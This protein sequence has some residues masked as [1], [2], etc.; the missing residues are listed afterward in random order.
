MYCAVWPYDR[1]RHVKTRSREVRDWRP[2]FRRN[3]WCHR[4]AKCWS[5]SAIFAFP[6]DDDLAS[7]G[8]DDDL[9]SPSKSSDSHADDIID[10]VNQR[11]KQL[12]RSMKRTKQDDISYAKAYTTKLVSAFAAAL[13]KPP[14]NSVR[15]VV[16]RSSLPSTWRMKSSQDRERV[17]SPLTVSGI[18]QQGH[19]IWG[20]P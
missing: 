13:R 19:R 17:S 5:Q 16:E 7:L 20:F 6:A 14:K 1:G 9:A 10:I 4:T 12:S 15:M 3:W 18:V 11:A 2:D 8:N